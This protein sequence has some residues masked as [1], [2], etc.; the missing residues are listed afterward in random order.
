MKGLSRLDVLITNNH[1]VK[2][3]QLMDMV[4]QCNHVPYPSEGRIANMD[5]F[6]PDISLVCFSKGTNFLQVKRLREWLGDDHIIIAVIDPDADEKVGEL[7]LVYGATRWIRYPSTH[8]DLC[9]YLQ[10]ALPTE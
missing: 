4:R 10:E 7:A 9:E 3:I 8:T 1:P 6:E 2:L 5:H